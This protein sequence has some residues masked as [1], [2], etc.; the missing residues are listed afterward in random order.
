[1]KTFESMSRPVVW[2]RTEAFTR[3][4]ERAREPRAASRRR[5]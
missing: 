1:M 3:T 2:S 5:V 4:S